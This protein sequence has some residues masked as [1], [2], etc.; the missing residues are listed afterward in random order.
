MRGENDED[1]RSAADKRHQHRQQQQQQSQQ[2]YLYHLPLSVRRRDFQSIAIGKILKTISS[3]LSEQQLHRW[4]RCFN[5]SR[6]AF[7]LF[8][9]FAMLLS[10]MRDYVDLCTAAIVCLLAAKIIDETAS[11]CSAICTELVENINVETLEH[12]LI[13]EGY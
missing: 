8:Y 7:F 4:R 3:L 12:E 6:K 13:V 1:E 2:H 11:W 5:H 10:V 9:L